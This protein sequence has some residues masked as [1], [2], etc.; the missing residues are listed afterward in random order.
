MSLENEIQRLTAAIEKLNSNIELVLTTPA[1][2]TVELPKKSDPAV[3]VVEVAKPEAPAA[4]P[5]LKHDDVQS[6]ILAKVRANMENKTKVKAILTEFK[7][8]KV[9]DLDLSVLADVM[10]KVDAL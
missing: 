1:N 7:A 2:Q 6:A 4:T 8:A 9:T 3:T 5:E 10:A